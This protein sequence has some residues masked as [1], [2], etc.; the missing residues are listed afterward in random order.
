MKPFGGKRDKSA[1]LGF[2]AGLG[3][4][5]ENDDNSCIEYFCGL[6]CVLIFDVS[7]S[8]GTLSSRGISACLEDSGF[9]HQSVS[10]Y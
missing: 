1:G 9:T 7:L 5:R 4:L 3:S 2:P 10:L 6:L 8:A